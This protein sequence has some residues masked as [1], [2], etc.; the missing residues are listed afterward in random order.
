MS[1]ESWTISRSARDSQ[2]SKK[3]EEQ[4]PQGNADLNLPTV[5]FGHGSGG[6]VPSIVIVA[7]ARFGQCASYARER[8]NRRPSSTSENSRL[9]SL[10]T[11]SFR[12]PCPK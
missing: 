5:K 2:Q 8:T 6:G 4:Q 7:V 9:A 12:T 10:L 11:F 3:G 1:T